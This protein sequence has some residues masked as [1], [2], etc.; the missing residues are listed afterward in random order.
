M[1]SHDFDDERAL[2]AGRGAVQ[3]IQGFDDPVQRR[4]RADR[5]VGTR[6]VVVD[7]SDETHQTQER[8]LIGEFL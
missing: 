3:G 8:V 7:G 4:I 5:H 2:V 6:H 1:A